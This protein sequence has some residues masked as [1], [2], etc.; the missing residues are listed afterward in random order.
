MRRVPLQSRKMK[1][2]KIVLSA[3]LVLGASLSKNDDVAIHQNPDSVEYVLDNPEVMK[4]QLP[5]SKC[6]H[7]QPNMKENL[8]EL[9][10]FT[11][12]LQEDDSASSKIDHPA[13]VDSLN[14]L[15]LEVMKTELED[16]Q[17]DNE[18]PKVNEN[19]DEMNQFTSGL[20]EDDSTS[21]K[22][23][24]PANV[25]LI[26]EVM[27]TEL[28]D[29]QS[30]NE[31]PKVN[32]NVE[33][34]NQ[35]TSGLQEDD[36]ASSKI[37][38]PANVDSLNELIFEVMKTMLPDSPYDHDHPN[39]KEN[40]EKLNPLTS[41]HV[42]IHQ[43]S[44]TLEYVPDSQ[45]VMQTELPFSECD[46]EQPIMKENLKEL[47]QF[48][49]GLQEDDSATIKIGHPVNV[50][51]LNEP[52]ELGFEQPNFEELKTSGSS[53]CLNKIVIDS[54]GKTSV[55]GS[56]HFNQLKLETV[57]PK[58]GSASQLADKGTA[59]GNEFTNAQ[60]KSPT[61]QSSTEKLITF[62][63]CIN[64]F[65][66][67]SEQSFAQIIACVTKMIIHALIHGTLLAIGICVSNT[68]INAVQLLSNFILM[69][70]SS[71]CGH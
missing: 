39:L 58:L 3:F 61:I 35:F 42:T 33:E 17:L 30:D 34:L 36:S 56:V 31:Q 64:Q 26:L 62:L 46:H 68:L 59:S 28:E 12:G 50:D 32:E 18:Q 41:D 14:E 13:N 4:S 66:P 9:N 23:D 65:I 40:L 52:I 37:D 10:Q 55:F 49:S 2:F 51:S 24:Y 57:S 8:K 60:G 54:D 67:A 7:E 29:A 6:D 5:N 38:H 21:S 22:I 44:D 63:S 19:G 43:K 53:E 11:S 25:E 70:I 71:I 27:K 20:Q 1:L 47:N 16:A 48:T 69:K 15:I 45:E